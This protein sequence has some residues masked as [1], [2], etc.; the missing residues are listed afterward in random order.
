MRRRARGLREL[1]KWPGADSEFFE[2]ETRLAKAGLAQGNDETTREWLK[3]ISEDVPVAAEVLETVIR[4]HQKY[5]FNPD[6]VT[7]A[8]RTQLKE[9]VGHC[10]AKV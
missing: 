8:E 1:Q 6:G 9:M 3:R 4:I 5:R 10:L 2:L 7:A